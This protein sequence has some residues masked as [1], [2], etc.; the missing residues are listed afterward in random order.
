MCFSQDRILDWKSRYTVGEPDERESLLSTLYPLPSTLYPLPST[1]SQP[2]AL[3]EDL[4]DYGESL[5]ICHFPAT[6]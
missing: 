1:H 3:T 2:Q 4:P 6:N 5:S